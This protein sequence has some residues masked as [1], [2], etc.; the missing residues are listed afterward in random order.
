[1]IEKDDLLNLII[2]D[3][4]SMETAL[5]VNGVVFYVEP[6]ENNLEVYFPNSDEILKFKDFNDLIENF[7]INGKP[8]KEQL[9]NLDYKW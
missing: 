1:M 2:S 4:N 3:I 9:D 5:Q 6:I 8:L 7:I